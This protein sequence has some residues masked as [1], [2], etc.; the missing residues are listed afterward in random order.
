MPIIYKLGAGVA[1]I[2]AVFYLGQWK[3]HND[4]KIEQLKD[5][6]EAVQ[7]RESIDSTI[8][9]SDDYAV[10]IALGGLPDDCR[11]LRRMEEAAKPE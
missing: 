7:T 3:G 8:N 2:L 4:G 6:V 1:V 11:A 9:N 5:S 10:C